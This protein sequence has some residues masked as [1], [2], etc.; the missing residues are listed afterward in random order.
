MNNSNKFLLLINL[1]NIFIFSIRDVE[2][3]MITKNDANLFIGTISFEFD[4]FLSPTI[5]C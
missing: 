4:I 3:H 1:V 5:C 2:I